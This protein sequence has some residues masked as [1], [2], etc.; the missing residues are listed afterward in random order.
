MLRNNDIRG[1]IHG[2]YTYIDD[3]MSLESCRDGKRVKL[4]PEAV[5]VSSPLNAQA[6]SKKSVQHPDKNS[7]STLSMASLTASK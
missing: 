4:P 1:E 5:R 6:W 7:L 3:L 2:D